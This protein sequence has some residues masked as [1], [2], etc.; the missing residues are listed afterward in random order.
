MGTIMQS[1]SYRVPV[2]LVAQIYLDDLHTNG[3]PDSCAEH[4]TSQDQP[5]FEGIYYLSKHELIQHA[6]MPKLASHML[7]QLQHQKGKINN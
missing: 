1:C 7:M 2:V 5:T 3:K 6:N 4:A